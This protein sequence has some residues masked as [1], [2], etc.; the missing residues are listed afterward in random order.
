[1]VNVAQNQNLN[2]NTST[3][4]DDDTNSSNHPLFLHQNDHSGL[5][6]ISKKLTGSDNYGS[7]K[8]STM[9]VLNAKNKLKLE[10]QKHYSQLDG[11]KVYQLT[12]DLV[13]LKQ[14]NL[15]IEIYYHKLKG[16]WDEYDSLETPYM[17]VCACVYE[18]GRINGERD[19]R[20]RLIQFLMGLDECYA[21]VRG[22][23]L[24]MNPMPTVA[25]AYSMIRQ[26]EKQRE[27][28]AFKNTPTVLSAQYNYTRN[29]YSNNTRFDN[30][31]FK[32]NYSQGESSSRNGNQGESSRRS[33][34]K[35]GVIC[36]N[37]GKNGHIK[38]ECYTIVGY[39]VRHPLHGRYRPS[40]QTLRNNSQDNN[41]T[42][43][44]TMSQGNSNES[45]VITTSNDA[46][47]NARMNQLQNQLNQMIL[48][49]QNNKETNG[50]PFIN[51]EEPQFYS[52]ASKDPRWIDAMNKELKALESND[53][54]TL[55]SLPP[56]KSHI[57]L[58]WVFRIKY[59]SD[60]SIER[61]KAR[62]V[63]KGCTQ[64]ER[65]YHNETFAPVAKMVTSYADT[66]LLTYKKGNAFLALVVYVVDIL[67]TG[68]NLKLINHIKHQLDITCNIKDLGSL[69]YYL[70]IEFLRN[71]DPIAKLNETDGDLLTDPSQCRA[72]V[73]K[74]LY[75]T[76]TRPDLS[77]AAHCL[78]QYSHSPRTPHLKALIKQSKK[79]SVV[80]RS[81]IEA[82]YRVL[83][84]CTCE[85]TWLLSLFKDLQI[86][87]STPIPIFC[88][89]QSS[90]SL[91]AN[92]VQH[93]ITKHVEID[94]HFVRK[95]IKA[96]ILLPIYL[97]THHQVADALTKGLSRSPFHKCISKFRM[98]DP[99]TLLTCRGQHRMDWKNAS[100]SSGIADFFRFLEICSLLKEMQA[101]NWN[102]FVCVCV[103]KLRALSY[104]FIRGSSVIRIIALCKVFPL[105]NAQWL[106][107]HICETINMS[108]GMV[109]S[110]LHSGYSIAS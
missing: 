34:F 43:N 14:N 40:N 47:M 57:G 83:A 91:A 45:T 65:T 46:A 84:D 106:D 17:C 73:G 49:M 75:F 31:R 105:K 93:A 35:K 72:L 23:I 39:P 54:W 101:E 89:N 38:E 13:Q 10:L 86:S 63:A 71:V 61:F 82:E 29:S 90:I 70:G 9:R 96:S 94:C 41:M 58:K 88:D 27:G 68:N 85:I 36:G 15:A 32:R 21:N 95:K 80:S 56:N 1:M 74:L 109:H 60:G 52:Q 44:M 79:Q 59:N 42:V 25:K 24:L 97:P 64:K 76:I 102:I 100:A 77:Y 3:A 87:T 50:I 48:M 103:L 92:P 99:Y 5:I 53:T 69:N 37:Y 110:G 81:S 62:L 55:T 67:F 18:N 51:N 28:S 30:S 78:S 11:H 107:H 19:Q 20:K 98:C 7:W 16:L 8:R 33:N 4:N 2:T 12:N 104:S 6:L 22:Q 66:T 26:E 108:K